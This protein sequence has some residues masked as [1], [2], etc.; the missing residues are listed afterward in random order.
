MSVLT[1]SARISEA[2]LGPA[3]RIR[4]FRATQALTYRLERVLDHV[5]RNLLANI[6]AGAD[7]ESIVH[8]TPDPDI[9]MLLGHF[10]EARELPRLLGVAH[11]GRRER[12]GL[13]GAE[14]RLQNR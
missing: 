4:G 14:S 8:T 10:S 5:G 2:S 6:L 1:F 7:R 9:L 3:P 11:I 12:N 13:H